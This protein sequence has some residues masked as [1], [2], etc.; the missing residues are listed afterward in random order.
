MKSFAGNGNYFIFNSE[1]N[2]EPMEIFKNRC[3]VAELW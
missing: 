2:G 1:M 3:N